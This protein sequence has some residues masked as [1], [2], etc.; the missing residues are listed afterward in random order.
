MRPN[1][2]N[3]PA[4]SIAQPATQAYGETLGLGVPT[5]YNLPTHSVVNLVMAAD[6]LITPMLFN[7]SP[8]TKWICRALAGL[9]L[10]TRMDS[11]EVRARL[12][13][14]VA[15]GLLLIGAALTGRVTSRFF[16]NMYLLFGGL[17]MVANA[18]MTEVHSSA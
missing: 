6:S 4:Q 8:V 10:V 1:M 15:V 11:L 16:E 5:R 12:Q 2:S 3:T 18:L 7:M 17:L 13:W 9:L 14:E